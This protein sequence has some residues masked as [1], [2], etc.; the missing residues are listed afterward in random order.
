MKN[1]RLSLPGAP[2][3]LR[4]V[5]P[6]LLATAAVGVALATQ[7]SIG[8]EAGPFD[9]R[10][11]FVVAALLF[12]A[13][14]FVLSRR[15]AAQPFELSRAW[16]WRAVI[17]VVGIALL[18]RIHQFYDFP[19]GLWYDEAINGTDALDIMGHGNHLTVWR[20]T[21]FGHSTLYFY[22]LMAS[23]KL[24]GFTI[25]AMRIVPV[26]AG[27]AAVVAFYFL[28]RRLL[29]V[30]GALAATGMMAVSR[31]A[32]TFSRISWEASLVPLLEIMSVY[33]FVR[34]L[35]TRRKRDWFMAGGSLAAGLYTYAAYR[36]VPFIMAF[37][38]LYLALTQW[39]LFRRNFLGL[40][41]YFVSFLIVV[42]P[43]A[44]FV[45]R[46][47]HQFN[48]R[49]NAVS[50]FKQIDRE[51]SYAPLRHNIVAV[52]KMMNVRGDPN[53]RHNLPNEP[54]L[55]GISAALLILG[56]AVAAWSFRDW[57]RGGLLGW[58]LLALVP[59]AITITI[60]NPSAI[61]D[62]GVIPPMF[63][64]VGL[65]VDTLYRTFSV[66]A[67]ARAVFAAIVL[68]LGAGAGAINYHV[69][70]DRQATAFSVHDSFQAIFTQTAKVVAEHA[71]QDRVYISP[72]QAHPALATLA[73]GK[74]YALYSPSANLIFPRGDKDVLIVMDSQQFGV[75]PTLRRLYPHLSV[76]DY[77]DPFGKVYWSEVRIPAADTAAVHAVQ[78]T[79]HDG[80]TPDGAVLQAPHGAAINRDWSAADLGSS[81]TVTA[82]WDA[83]VWIGSAQDL[84]A[85]DF[86]GP[87]SVTIEIDGKPAAAGR[88]HAVA[89]LK[90]LP[91][92][93]HR[94]RIT[95]TIS[96]PGATALAAG[97]GRPGD[98]ALYATSVG[99]HGFEAV[100]HP[101]RDFAARPSMI[102]RYPFA[103]AA[104]S[105][106]GAQAI[107]YRATFSVPADGDYGFALGG[108]TAAQLF[109]DDQLLADNG[110]SHAAR[111]TEGTIP[112]TA[113]AHNF[114]IQYV[115]VTVPDWSAFM[116][117]PGQ[118]WNLLDGSEFSIPTE[119]YKPASLVTIA[120]DP[121]WAGAAATG[122]APEP[123]AVTL[124]ADGTIV[125]ASKASLVF[126]S[127]TG[128]VQRTTALPDG[129]E[130]NDLAIDVVGEIVAGDRAGKALLIIGADG[131]V[132][133]RI[134]GP[135]DSVTGVEVHGGDAY[136]ASAAGGVLYRVPLSGGAPEQLEFSKGSSP[137]RAAQPSDIAITS[138][139]TYLV[140]DF[141]R[142]KI[143]ISPDGVHAT[144]V[145]GIGGVGGQ[146]PRTVIYGKFV[147][148]SDPTNDRIVVYDQ[149]GR[150]RGAY[151]FPPSTF[152]TRPMGMAVTPEGLLYVIGLN[153]GV[154]RLQVTVP[155]ALAAELAQQ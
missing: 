5:A 49:A 124:L 139:G 73:H 41:F 63:L 85:L 61:R 130:I 16:E 108:S 30:V 140:T 54:M 89:D 31:Y 78:M 14:A 58:Y 141:E 84:G 3:W 44:Q 112:L 152:G 75:L 104:D 79:V 105:L 114:M 71:D 134:A 111:R 53:A 103:V 34:A 132:L 122:A 29:G 40:V 7:Y 74:Q 9:A 8:H 96:Q 35:E 149:R 100:Y 70:F 62:I 99:D 136:V 101:G 90:L 42:A 137:V 46:H 81:G 28:A 93:E 113:G 119:P 142:K 1:A 20:E 76:R 59:S 106:P 91:F 150:Q 97:D 56:M 133:R 69:L 129:V 82:I 138:D 118:D 125:V 2:S 151:A 154:L 123:S 24:F 98:E 83:Y 25:L 148:V 27:L 52:A 17:V 102:A 10:I 45:V 66:N 121:S 26:A 47:P 80:A 86:S 147:L 22:L 115:V 107:E 117:V 92:G 128:A 72:L 37:F 6:A 155:P 120:P 21:N 110:G 65:A 50:V 43:L 11:G 131:T 33:F 67:W 4:A 143:V 48:A 144:D 94:V 39:R 145:S 60:E 77:R 18:F 146:V 55:D 36:M 38:V 57:R 126:V 87:G 12:V 153:G 23:F 13:A 15:P 109:V 116:R 127:P 19:P 88:A 135:F 68:V 64:L 95:A 51:G 32:V